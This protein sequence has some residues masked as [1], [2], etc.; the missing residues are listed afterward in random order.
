MPEVLPAA[1]LSPLVMAAGLA[2]LSLMPF[3]LVIGTCFAKFSLV[4][5]ILRNAIG[6]QNAPSGM[7]LNG[8]SLVLS[9][10]VMS[11][12][13]AAM[14]DNAT[15]FAETRAVNGA[16]IR[17]SL[18]HRPAT[19]GNRPSSSQ[20]PT[21]AKA[22]ET[23]RSPAALPESPFEDLSAW[24]ANDWLDAAEHTAEPWRAFLVANA[25]ISELVF[26]HELQDEQLPPSPDDI[27]LERALPA[28]LLTEL[29]EAFQIGFLLFLPFLLVDL[30]VG[31]ILLALGMHMLTPT[32][33]SLPFKLLL[34]VV[35]DGW[36]SVSENLV[37]GYVIP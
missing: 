16:A 35:V 2:L 15:S 18:D 19:S 22:R 33:V 8:L 25:G 4:L 31:S 6:A 10:V 28:F 5:S 20:K 12:V 1:P 23:T 7:I 37:L 14:W 11:P 32:S 24:S 36:I 13:C 26:F 30:L 34:F 21:T 17:P 3:L 9:L 29:A 27:G